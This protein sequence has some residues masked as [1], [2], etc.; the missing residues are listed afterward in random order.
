MLCSRLL[1]C[2]HT[3]LSVYRMPNNICR[4]ASQTDVNV[5]SSFLTKLPGF[6]VFVFLFLLLRRDLCDAC[7]LWGWGEDRP[8]DCSWNRQPEEPLVCWA[9]LE[10]ILVCVCCVSALPG[11]D[12]TRELLC[13]EHIGSRGKRASAEPRGRWLD[14]FTCLRFWFVLWGSFCFSRNCNVCF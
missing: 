2:C 8:Q 4:A 14:Q 7:L 3:H 6:S 13:A 11:E 12:W 5:A 1:L 10:K 9:E